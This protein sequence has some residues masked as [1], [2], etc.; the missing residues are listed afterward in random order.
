MEYSGILS[1][2]M[3]LELLK[4]LAFIKQL[5]KIFLWIV[6]KRRQRPLIKTWYMVLIRLGFF[7][8]CGIRGRLSSFLASLFSVGRSSLV[9]AC[10]P[11]APLFPFICTFLSEDLSFPAAIFGFISTSTEAGLGDNLILLLAPLY[12]PL[13]RAIFL[14]GLTVAGQAWAMCSQPLVSQKP[15]Q[16]WTA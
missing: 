16:S 7:L 5:I 3:F 13:S 15:S 11:F 9:S 4:K 1:L 6:Y 2:K 12:C 8:S 14:L 10:F